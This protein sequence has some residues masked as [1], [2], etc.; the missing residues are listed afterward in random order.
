MKAFWV[1]LLFVCACAILPPP[2]DYSAV[3][4]KYGYALFELD[5][6]EIKEL[7]KRRNC[8]NK[9]FCY[10]SLRPRIQCQKKKRFDV[11]SNDWVFGPLG[12]KRR[13]RFCKRNRKKCKDK[14]Y[15]YRIFSP[16][17]KCYREEAPKAIFF[18]I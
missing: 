6:I 11:L 4:R 17:N 1:S 10:W 5:E 14:P 3:H 16:D 8:K 12:T 13:Q 7:C 18:Y 2:I 15:C 9:P